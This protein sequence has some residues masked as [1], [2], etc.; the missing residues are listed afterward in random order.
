MSIKMRFLLSYVG[1]IFFSIILLLTAGFL[2]IFAITGDAKSI[3]SLYK[4][5]YV[6][7]P[8]TTEEESIFL[9][10]KLL[11]K[12]DSKQLLDENEV[13]SFE[14][15]DIQI[16]VRKGTKVEYASRNLDRQVLNQSLPRFEKTNINTR[17]IIKMNNT[18]FT[19][20]KFDFYFS[21]QKEG[22]IFV[23]RKASSYTE[24]IREFFPILSGLLLILFIMI[25][26]IVNYFVSRSIIKPLDRLKKAAEK[27]ASGDLDFAIKATSKDEIGQLNRAFEEMR[28]RLKES[29]NLQI[30]YEENRKE[31][32]SNISHD[33]KTPM[34]SIIG[35]MEGIKDG[36]AN[37]PEK[38]EKYVSTVYVKA[39]DMD[40]LIDELFLFS[41]LDLK[42]EPFHFEMVELNTY[43]KDYV[44]KL[45]LDQS[46]HID[47]HLLQHSIYVTVDREKLKRVV[48]NV[49]NNCVKYMDK[50]EK[51]ISISLHERIEDVVIQITDNGKGIE[52]VA[53]PFIF[54][55]FYRAEQSRNSQTGG[56][57]LGLAIAKQIIVEHGG[58]IWATSEIG[59]GTSICF[60][61]KKGDYR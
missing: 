53:L 48:A 40:S 7:K 26:G 32:L 44:E 36:I 52:S 17:D 20:V 35:Y 5:T 45:Y 22:S 9:D 50:D 14:H 39:K 10:L 54:E 2:I 1:V 59:K 16:V 33:L 15:G 47:L 8:L 25:I 28:S 43:L 46:I 51:N 56:S 19:Y 3:E 30:Q 18:F 12:N 41:K 58:E 42:K 11:A 38:M 61:L 31:L 4:K 55:R 37:T 34:T 57:G 21:D 60:S 13:R 23:L 29:V 6:Q 49:I 24:L 27:I